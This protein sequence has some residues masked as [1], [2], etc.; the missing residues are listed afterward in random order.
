MAVTID[1]GEADDIHPKNKQD[2][3][4]R[5]ALWALGTTYDQDI[6]RSGPLYRS[7]RQ[8]NG[9]IVIAFDYVGEGLVAKG[10]QLKGF[11]IAGAD[12]EFVFAD[13]EIKGDAVIV[14]S[15]TVGEPVAVRYAWASNPDC[16]LYNKCGLP[17]SPF[18]TDDW[19]Q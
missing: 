11:A 2:V 13:A 14:S 12:Q 8:E 9:K 16:N 6:V 18:R 15:P 1:V 5:L 4:K 7:H 19:K 10:E 3:G 17:A